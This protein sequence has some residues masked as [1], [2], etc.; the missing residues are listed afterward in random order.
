MIFLP[1]TRLLPKKYYKQ[2]ICLENG[3]TLSHFKT[4]DLKQF[5]KRNTRERMKAWFNYYKDLFDETNLYDY[6]E[7][8]NQDECQQL[9][10]NIEESVKTISKKLYIPE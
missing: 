9:S 6:W 1:P 5:K 8:E 7:K 4:L 3:L 2:N 10:N